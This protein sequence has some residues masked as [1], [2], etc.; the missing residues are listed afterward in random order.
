MEITNQVVSAFFKIHDLN[1]DILVK[2]N[3]PGSV[4]GGANTFAYLFEQLV[5]LSVEREPLG[6]CTSHS[7]IHAQ[8]QKG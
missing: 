6:R 2:S 4:H 3:A 1:G 8:H 7:L 5:V